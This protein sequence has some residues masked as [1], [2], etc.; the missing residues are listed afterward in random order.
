MFEKKIRGWLLDGVNA[1]MQLA[2]K[3]HFD[4]ALTSGGSMTLWAMFH[5]TDPNDNIAIILRTEIVDRMP[6]VTII[7]RDRNHQDRRIYKG[8]LH[9]LLDEKS[10]ASLIKHYAQELLK[11]ETDGTASDT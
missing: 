2:P 11:G 6:F 7:T 3:A 8:R 10:K 4:T 9:D 1:D 5:G